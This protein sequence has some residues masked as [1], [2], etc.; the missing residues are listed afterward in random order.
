MGPEWLS[1]A[2]VEAVQDILGS[3]AAGALSVQHSRT[4]ARRTYRHPQTLTDIPRAQQEEDTH[5]ELQKPHG[6]C[7]AATVPVF[8][9]SDSDTVWLSPVPSPRLDRRWAVLLP[10]IP[11][12]SRLNMSSLSPILVHRCKRP[13]CDGYEPALHCLRS[14]D[15]CALAAGLPFGLIMMLISCGPVQS[16]RSFRAPTSS[17]AI[18]SATLWLRAR[19]AR[20][21]ASAVDGVPRAG[22]R[23]RAS[24]RHIIA[25]P[26]RSSGCRAALRPPP[27]LHCRLRS[28]RL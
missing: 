14:L 16:H 18:T 24:C 17:A 20:C 9:P 6:C 26:R 15:A 4:Y 22:E 10:Y 7:N 3:V 2:A 19:S 23:E 28:L 21:D 25:R 11:R 5:H 1:Q 12:T 27:G 8:C 13:P